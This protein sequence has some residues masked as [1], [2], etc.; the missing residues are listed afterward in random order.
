M[1]TYLQ[2]EMTLVLY[3]YL[4]FVKEDSCGVRCVKTNNF[5]SNGKL[6]IMLSGLVLQS[7][8]YVYTIQI[9]WYLNIF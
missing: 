6:H 8:L 9:R 1:P 5:S 3:L 7:L 4:D 2:D